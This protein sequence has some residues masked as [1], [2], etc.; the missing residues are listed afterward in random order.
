MTDS[1]ISLDITGV[2][3]TRYKS[4]SV[5]MEWGMDRVTWGHGFVW[6]GLVQQGILDLRN[7]DSIPW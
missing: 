7:S 6:R 4:E 2:V 5:S 3:A 1:E